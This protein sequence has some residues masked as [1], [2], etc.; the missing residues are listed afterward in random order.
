VFCLTGVALKRYLDSLSENSQVSRRNILTRFFGWCNVSPDEAVAFQRMV[1]SRLVEFDEGLLEH[2]RRCLSAVNVLLGPDVDYWFVDAAHTWLNSK[3]LTV[4]TKRTEYGCISGFFISNR[5]GLPVD[6]RRFKSSKVPV[7]GSLSV[8]ELRQIVVASNLTYRAA[9]LCM[10]NCGWGIGELLFVNT[11]HSAQVF[12]DVRMGKEFVCVS[13]PGRKRQRNERPFYSFIGGDALEA[14]RMLFHSRGWKPDSV[15]FRNER[16]DP[17]AVGGLQAYFRNKALH[18]GFIK[19]KTPLCPVCGSVTI[20]KRIIKR[21]DGRRTDRTYYLCTNFDCQKATFASELPMSDPKAFGGFRYRIKVHEIR[22]LFRTEWHRAQ[23]YAGVD[24]AVGE[25]FLGHSIDPLR[26]DKIMRD[27]S[28]T[29]EHYRKALPFLNI[30]SENPRVVDRAEVEDE[31]EAIKAKSLKYEKEIARL[32]QDR[33]GFND[34]VELLRDP[35]KLR[36]F[37][38]LIESG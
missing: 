38:K 21:V 8:D 1:S 10:Y 23:A 36:K 16:G 28:Y 7:E 37:K 14:L 5:G 3:N 13:L 32:K 19:R 2:V 22:D 30:L 29:L 27:K 6:R 15:I 35:E 34:L 24:G 17:L 18:L 33:E 9:F 20:K 11:N 25:F 4:I 12:N 31:I 26:Y